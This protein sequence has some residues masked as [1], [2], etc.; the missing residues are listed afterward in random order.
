DTVVHHESG[1]VQ[2]HSVATASRSKP[3]EAAG[4][5]PVEELCRV[6]ADNF[7][8]AECGR[9]EDADAVAHGAAFARDGGMHVLAIVREAP[10]ALPCPDI[11]EHRTLSLG[12]VVHRRAANR[13]E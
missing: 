6:G 10:R 8:L 12:P 11:L 7:D 3:G 1:L 13:L 9:I 4:V 5:E 2:Q